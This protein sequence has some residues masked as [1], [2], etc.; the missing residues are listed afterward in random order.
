VIT[1]RALDEA[2]TMVRVASIGFGD[3]V[4]SAAMR[5]FFEAG[6]QHTISNLQKHFAVAKGK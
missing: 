5:K 3:D 2:R 1:L 4:E 6:N